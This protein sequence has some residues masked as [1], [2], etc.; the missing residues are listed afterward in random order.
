MA[1]NISG[2]TGVDK[3]QDGT[4]VDADFASGVNVGRKNLIINGGFDVWQRGTS[5]GLSAVTADRWKASTGTTGTISR[6]NFT[7]GQTDVPNEPEFYLSYNKTG[8]ADYV[9]FYHP[10][11]GVRNGA[12]Q[13]VTLSF[14]AKADASTTTKINLVQNFGS[15]GSTA[16]TTSAGA[17]ETFTTSWQRFTKTVTLP[18][19]SGKTIGT[20]N[21]LRLDFFFGNQISSWTG[22][23]DIANV[24][25]EIG[26]TATAF[27]HRSY[28][29]ELALCQRYFHRHDVNKATG[30][31]AFVSGQVQTTTEFYGAYTHPVQMRTAPTYSVSSA[32]AFRVLHNGVAPATTSTSAI[33]NKSGARIY[34]VSSGLTAGSGAVIDIGSSSGQYADFSSEL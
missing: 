12:G 27:E 19:I 26:S 4:I 16:V 29:E 28:G 20:S 13:Q 18:S 32:T 33:T 23:V 6:Q 25:L 7:V 15:G 31:M 1:T 9:H 3:V 2:S 30:G 10:I 22:T 17:N 24:Q 34:F 8:T 11:E 14:Y 21:Y 5:F